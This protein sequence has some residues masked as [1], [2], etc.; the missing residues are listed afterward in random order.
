MPR[1]L[2]KFKSPTHLPLKPETDLKYSVSRGGGDAC[3]P[4]R[5]YK[6][7]KRGRRAQGSDMYKLGRIESPENE[8]TDQGFI[9]M[10]VL[11]IASDPGDVEY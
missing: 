4:S 11:K 9:V 1:N 10:G 2:E 7:D 3:W 8:S 6:Q 5:T